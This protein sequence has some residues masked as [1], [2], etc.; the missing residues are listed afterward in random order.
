M[1]KNRESRSIFWM[2]SNA[3]LG[4]QTLFCSQQNREKYF[5]E[6]NGQIGMVFQNDSGSTLSDGLETEETRSWETSKEPIAMICDRKY[7]N[8]IFVQW[9]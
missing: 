8:L 4:F 5:E 1:N 7:K 3:M 9:Q 6:E 2:S